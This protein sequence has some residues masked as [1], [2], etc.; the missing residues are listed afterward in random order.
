MSKVPRENFYIDISS[1]VT[2]IISGKRHY[3]IV[4]DNCNKNLWSLF[5]KKKI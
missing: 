1:P 2:K 4:M 3:F 5:I